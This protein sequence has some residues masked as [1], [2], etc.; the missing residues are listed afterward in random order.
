M[1]HSLSSI[2]LAVLSLVAPSTPRSAMV[3]G[4][5]G[6]TSTVQTNST[7]QQVIFLITGLSSGVTYSVSWSCSGTVNTCA[8]PRGTSFTGTNGSNWP[9]TFNAGV[10]GTGTITLTVTGGG[11]S[12][13]GSYTVTVA[14]SYGVAVTP[15]GGTAAGRTANTGLYSETFTV[16]NT[17]WNQNTYSFTCA[18]AGGVTCGTVPAPITVSGGGVNSQTVT[19]PYSV[20][21][22]GNGTL[23]LTA[24]GTSASD[25]GSYTV[26]IITTGVSVTPDGGIAQTRFQNATGLSE[27]F[28]VKNTGTTAPNTYSFTCA[29]SG[30]VTCGTVPAA[31]QIAAGITV[32]VAM[33][34]T[35][36]SQAGT[37]TLTLTATGT[38]ASDA[39]SFSVPIAVV[40]SSVS[41]SFTKDIRYLLVETANQY[42]AYG[43][44]TQ[45]TDARSQVTNYVY[46][47]GTSAFLTQVKQAKDPAGAID[48]VTN[49]GYDGNNYVAS[50]Q[51][52]GGS[53]RY[54]FYDTFGRLR[55]VKNTALDTV[56]AYGYTYSRTSGNGWA[57]QQSTPNTVVD[58][59]VM[60]KSPS[61]RVTGTQYID[62]LGRPIQSSVKNGAYYV[63]TA[64]QYDA[65]GRVWRSWKPDTTVS[66]VYD[67][68]FPT[69]ATNWY[70]AYHATS[71]AHPYTE[72]LYTTD[73]LSRTKWLRPEYL[74]AQLTDS[75]TNVFGVVTGSGQAYREVT[76][77]S[78][79]K[80]R[81]YFDLFGNT[82]KTILGYGATEATTTQF[83][84]NILGQRTQATDPRG[85]NTTY[86]LDTRG[87]LTTSTS[88]DAGIVSYQYDKG[89][90]LRFVQDANEA[91]LG[92][93][94]FNSYDFANRDTVSG[95]GSAVFSGLNPDAS[96]TVETT[97]G[98]WLVVR[99]YDN[100]PT[101]AGFPWSLFSAQITP[102]L[103]MSNLGGRLAAV[104]S[105]SNGAWQVTLFSYDADGQVTNR[106]IFTQANGGASVLTAINTTLGYTRDVRGAL[107][108]RTE[109]VGSS[110]FYLYYDYD[111]RG[112]LNKTYASTTLG[113]PASADVT[114][115]LLP[116]G[117]PRTYQF[118]N[119]P[120]VP[121]TYT[122]RGQ[123]ERIADPTQVICPT[124]PFA[125][126]YKYLPNGLVDTA[127]FYN[128]GSSA[129]T[130]KRY[131]YAFGAGAY[132]AL[133]RMKFADYSPWTGGSWVPT[134]AYDINSSITPI[135]Y[136]VD[137]NI[138]AMQRYRQDGSLIDN[139]TY[140]YPSNSN[141]LSSVGD[142]VGLTTEP[143]DAEG[144]S[145]T[146]DANGNV[147]TTPAPYSITAI[148]YD[149]AN[150][151]LS[152]T[153]SGTTTT[154][155]YDDAGQRITK[156]GTGNTEVYLR[157]GATVLG[158]F[159]V[160][161][162]G[163]LVSSYFNLLW[164]NR[165]V[166]RQ[167]NPSGTRSYYHFDM[168]G[169]TRSVT[170]GSTVVESHDYDP[171]GLEMPARAL[172]S[173]TKEAFSSKEQ[174]AETGLDYFGARYYMPALGTWAA[175]D[176]MMDS[177]M[178]WSSYAY[179]YDDPMRHSDPDGKQALTSP[180]PVN[181]AD[182]NTLH[183]YGDAISAA[184]RESAICDQSV[185]CRAERNGPEAINESWNTFGFVMGVKDVALLGR[186]GYEVLAASG[187]RRAEGVVTGDVVSA[188]GRGLANVSTHL[189]PDASQ[190]VNQGDHLVLGLESHGLERT[191]QLVGGRTLMSDPNWSQ[192][193]I[194]AVADPSTRF[195]F[196]LEGLSG[197][198]PL[199]KVMQIGRAHV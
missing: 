116:T 84:Y 10:P 89:R 91:A 191:A 137:G 38:G 99:H 123:T 42:D 36:G 175:V 120:V 7:G 136:N 151:P 40:L 195:T 110:T 178:E 141:R 198:T 100:K 50:I 92:R 161:G 75:I 62:G 66:A 187:A 6:G 65:M 167:P 106:Y 30:G 181:P 1:T 74:T 57:F 197:S 25:A 177:T 130:Q 26:P 81:D 86:T 20:G 135:T 22:P 127:E 165:V 48:L 173:G 47:V 67:G 8:S 146:Y 190:L 154:Y 41:G 9:I 83:S 192:T 142:A 94:K 131:R 119:G 172:G 121:I 69:N 147:K 73:A 160:N 104:A 139:L 97:Q 109:T 79:K 49:I 169:S 61:V 157:E 114:D 164:E 77:A 15:D 170:Q 63:V 132:D 17:G 80:T 59:T 35:V 107:T 129:T 153:S 95:E 98:N 113:K 93:V 44:I 134:A 111:N 166:G 52:P 184:I 133:N 176:P 55:V 149:P 64:T 143:W 68:S 138:T 194:D 168:L 117:Q 183:N 163:S 101:I 51:D 2:A 43:Q 82:V 90:N 46:G 27:T 122:I 150:L 24:T 14:P 33:P 145:F 32:P 96:N 126:R 13:Q 28:Y 188:G 199:D 152:V 189:A 29:S 185:R 23:T 39:G 87:L 12:A 171:W 5:S 182:V 174:D 18:G 70:N 125:A 148:S 103:T 162:S 112:L 71:T 72:T 118:L 11:S 34:Y 108:Q 53:F 56:R 196:S 124:C 3:L 60:S 156:Q 37:G 186:A 88:P 19:M 105:K 21:A 140:S 4:V 193:V 45:L 180:L 78:G 158:V 31:L 54:F 144:G 159:T 16:K 85:L 102:S 115:S 128:A 179:V 76:D 58:S 155:R